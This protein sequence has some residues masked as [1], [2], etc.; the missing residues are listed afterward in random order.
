M[1]ENT[2]IQKR[3]KEIYDELMEFLG[4]PELKTDSIDGV[5]QQ[6]ATLSSIDRA[7]KEEQY[8]AALE[9]ANRILELEALGIEYAKQAG[10]KEARKKAKYKEEKAQ[11]IDVES[12]EEKLDELS[13][14]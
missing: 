10:V 8:T 13:D 4:V 14:A 3:G 6:L 7:A 5:E 9:E 11:G 1:S 2:H 12:V